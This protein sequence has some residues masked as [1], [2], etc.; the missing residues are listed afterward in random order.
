MDSHR[1]Y[2]GNGSVPVAFTF[3]VRGV[4]RLKKRMVIFCDLNL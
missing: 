3:H 2:V 1:L 4:H